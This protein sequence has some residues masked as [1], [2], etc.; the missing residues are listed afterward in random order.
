MMDA[1]FAF[2]SAKFTVTGLALSWTRRSTYGSV[3]SLAAV[4]PKLPVAFRRVVE[5][6]RPFV[7]VEWR[8]TISRV[9]VLD[10]SA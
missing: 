1:I 2:A 5:Q 9:F 6:D 7:C 4:T 8:K 10:I 3:G